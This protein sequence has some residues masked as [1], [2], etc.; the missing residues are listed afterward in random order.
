MITKGFGV[1]IMK[2]PAAT[3]ISDLASV[4]LSECRPGPTYC[5]DGFFF[6]E[7]GLAVQVV[8][9]STSSGPAARPISGLPL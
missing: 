2:Q 9:K 6:V 3:A 7:H 5:R 8:N 1:T 4:A